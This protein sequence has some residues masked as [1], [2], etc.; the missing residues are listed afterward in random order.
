LY[1]S[2]FGT[3]S[4]HTDDRTMVCLLADV[5]RSVKDYCIVICD[6]LGRYS[7]EWQTLWSNDLKKHRVMDYI[8]SYIYDVEERERQRSE[9]QHLNLRLMSRQEIDAIIRQASEKA[10]VAIRPL[11]FVDRSVFVGRHMDTAEYN[12][13]AQPVRN[14]VNSLHEPNLRTDLTSLI[15]NY[16]PK[17]GFDFVNDYFEHL[18]V[19]WNTLVQFVGKLL[20]NYDKHSSQFLT[21]VPAI[22]ATYPEPLREA[23]DKMKRVVEGVGWLTTGLPRENIIEPQFGYAL[24]HLETNLQQG[25]GCAHG[26]VGI[27]EIDKT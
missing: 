10:G 5:A 13:R 26:I 4:H 2:S 3:S 12:P 23:M 20:V 7:Y 24:R 22:P 25:Q 21:E 15:I 14:A 19:C 17:P 9:L 18:Q 11:E 27:F 8:V 1:F 6:W 16:V